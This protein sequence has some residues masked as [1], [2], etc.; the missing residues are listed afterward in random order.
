MQV[1]SAELGI[2]EGEYAWTARFQVATPDDYQRIQVDDDLTV[3]I[4]GESYALIVDNKELQRTG[5]RKESFVV[6]AISPTSRLSPAKGRL[7]D[8][9]WDM[10]VQARAAAEE[11]AGQP[12]DWNLIDWWI[13]GGRLAVTRAAPLDIIKTIAGAAGGVVMTRPDGVLAVRHAFPT[14]VPSWSSVTVDHILTDTLDNLSS[15]ESYRSQRRVNRVVVRGYLPGNPDLSVEI[16]DRDD[17]L[18]AG[19]TVFHGGETVSF[20]A[21]SGSEIAGIRA[22][23][24]AG[25]LFPRARQAYQI[26]RDL[27]F[28]Q[29]NLATLDKPVTSIDAVVWLGNDLGAL[30]LGSDGRTV[31][32]DRVGLAIARVTCTVKAAAWG[33]CAPFSLGGGQSRF[34]IR[35]QVTGDVTAQS[36]DGEIIC[37]RGDGEFFGDDISDPLLVGTQE[38]LSRG[39]MAI[40]SGEKF[41]E[42]QLTCVFR[43]GIMP[44]HLI[45]VHDAMMGRSWRGQVTGVQ[46]VIHVPKVTTVIDI[47]RVCQ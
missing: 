13:P 7:F 31:M 33:L 20:L 44:G 35:V 30:R 19:R 23:S 38:M 43:P 3:T 18:N 21:H 6:A 8:K 32:S 2:A 36:G 11:V 4:G 10:P 37:Q 24:S 12:V 15:R 42:I 45:E 29:A 25:E 39:R 46:H 14:P 26:T 5:G 40:D 1:L 17:G 9:T 34:A 27:A 41:Q 22:S 16:D 28:D 47:L